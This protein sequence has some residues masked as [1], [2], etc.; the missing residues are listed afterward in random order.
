M[1][2]VDEIETS[3]WNEWFRTAP[4]ETRWVMFVA[5]DLWHHGRLTF[6]NQIHVVFLAF[7]RR[8][9]NE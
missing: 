3:D 2:D 6:D 5:S 4:I 9:S 1:F 8:L 7:I